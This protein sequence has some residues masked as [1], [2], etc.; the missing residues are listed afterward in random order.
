MSDALPLPPRP[1]L[2]QYKKL[3]RDFQHAC[4]SSDLR[5]NPR[6]GRSLGRNACPAAR[7]ARSQPEVRRADRTRG[8]SDRAT[9]AQVQERQMTARRAC[10]LADAQFFVARGHGFASWPKFARHLEAL[11]RANSPVSKFEAAVDAIVNGDPATLE[12]L[13]QRKSGAGAGAFD[14]RTS[15]DSAPLRLGE[16]R[17]G[18]PPEDAEEHCRDHE[19]ACWMPAPMSMRSPTR[20]AA[21]RQRWD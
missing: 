8:R 15:L 16:R 4:K 6:L 9:L 20:M 3:A 19:A 17:R 12:K 10:T 14:A 2:E 18:L 7:P 1:N 11:A 5:R 13:L 21:D